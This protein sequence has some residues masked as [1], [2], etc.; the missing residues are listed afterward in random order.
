MTLF[1]NF[2]ECGL[3]FIF[4]ESFPEEGVGRAVM[5]RLMKAAGHRVIE[6]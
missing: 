4:A 3:D 6:A 1:A 2:D 5:N